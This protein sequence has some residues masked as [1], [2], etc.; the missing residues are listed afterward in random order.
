MNIE[1]IEIVDQEDGGA[2]IKFDMDEDLVNLFIRQGMRTALEELAEK[3]VVVTTQEWDE[4]VAS[5]A[6]VP[7]AKNYEMTAQE[8]QGFYQIG[9]LKA[10]KYGV[11]RALEEAGE[12]NTEQLELD[13]GD[14]NDG[15]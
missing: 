15:C 8:L 14:E 9:M 11:D 4:W 3:Y 1:V 5:G 2:V 10:I 7:V 6:E 13:F 12:E